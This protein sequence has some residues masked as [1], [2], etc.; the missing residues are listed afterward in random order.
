MAGVQQPTYTILAYKLRKI[1][2]LRLQEINIMSYIYLICWLRC[3]MRD[4]EAL[5]SDYQVLWPLSSVWNNL[6]YRF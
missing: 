1:H 3:P 5:V 4:E 2:P 6:M